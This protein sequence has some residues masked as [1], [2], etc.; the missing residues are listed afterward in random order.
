MNFFVISNWKGNYTPAA[1][2]NALSYKK[3]ANLTNIIA[4]NY[5]F[6]NQLSDSSNIDLCSQ[7]FVN[8]KETGSTTLDLIKLFNIKY[9]LC[10][11]AEQK[12]TDPICYITQ[13]VKAG[14]T[15]I[16]F[17]ENAEEA[18]ELGALS[19]DSILVLEPHYA[20]GNVKTANLSNIRNEIDHI[21]QKLDNP[22]CYG[23][24]LNKTNYKEF[25]QYVDGLCFGRESLSDDF[26][27]TILNISKIV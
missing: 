12:L 4:P 26:N 23:G 19:K 2:Q 17:I 7:H 21:R 15:P 18:N 16:I 13:V 22:I 14:L 8:D 25:I 1:I 27:N 20:I 9:V 11:H 6:F 10:N 3:I 24:S 5:V